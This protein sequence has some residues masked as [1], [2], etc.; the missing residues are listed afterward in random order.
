MRRV[1]QG[2][3]HGAQGAGEAPGRGGGNSC[4]IWSAFQA[5]SLWT[6]LSV[7]LAFGNSRGLSSWVFRIRLSP[8]RDVSSLVSD[9]EDFQKCERSSEKRYAAVEQVPQSFLKTQESLDMD[10]Q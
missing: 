5:G 3:E 9:A 6:C 10:R 7:C 4:A 1:R 8:L 2:L